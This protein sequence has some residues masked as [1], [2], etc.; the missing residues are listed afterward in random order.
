MS[1]KSSWILGGTALAA[2]VLAAACGGGG[3]ATQAPAPQASAPAQAEAVVS[4]DPATAASLSGKIRYMGPAPKPARIRMDAEPTCEHEHKEP[5]Y[6][7]EIELGADGALRNAFVFV[8]AGL[9]AGKFAVP[10]QPVV[11][12]QKGC[13]Y[14]PHVVGVM[15]GQ[16]IQVKNSDSTTHNI[17]PLPTANREW[18][19]SQAPGAE[20]LVESFARE[21]IAIPVKCNVHPWMKSYIAVLKHPYFAVTGQDGSFKIGNLPPGQYTIEVWHEKLGTMDKQVTVGASESGTVDFEYAAGA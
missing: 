6:S 13:L 2:A 5:V 9:P 10:S 21:E 14:H 8:K 3:D 4:V 7:E 19:K 11:L 16:E 1:N 20:P 18:N 15:T 17:H 12:D